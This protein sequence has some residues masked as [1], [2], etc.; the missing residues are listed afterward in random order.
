MNKFK[1]P[2]NVLEVPE[3]VKDMRV[4]NIVAK[5]VKIYVETKEKGTDDAAIYSALQ[6]IR[7][8][9][10]AARIG[11]KD[12]PNMGPLLKWYLGAIKL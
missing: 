9:F 2:K 3:V 4:T 11:P 12:V 6:P 8:D 10:L 1:L 5:I 7:Q